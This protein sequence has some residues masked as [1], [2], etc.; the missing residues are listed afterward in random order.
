MSSAALNFHHLHSFWSVAKDG[1]L[2]HAAARLRVAP[3]IACEPQQWRGRL[4][5]LLS[6]IARP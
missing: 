3:R 5:A 1:T 6:G 4:D 2:T